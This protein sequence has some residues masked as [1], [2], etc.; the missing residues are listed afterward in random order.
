V[1]IGKDYIFVTR[2][3]LVQK[4][5]SFLCRA[6]VLVIFI[7][8]KFLTIGSTCRVQKKTMDKQETRFST[9]KSMG[10][11]LKKTTGEQRVHRAE[12]MKSEKASTGSKICL[13][14]GCKGKASLILDNKSAMKL[15]WEVKCS[16]QR[17]MV[18]TI[19]RR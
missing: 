16:N 19:R 2:I 9:L 15:Q 17:E 7:Q 14:T 6:S 3:G 18:S 12:I 11:M 5:S 13:K 4:E 8:L 10:K 1:R